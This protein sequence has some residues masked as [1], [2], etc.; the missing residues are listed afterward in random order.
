[1]SKNGHF[2]NKNTGS[3]LAL[4]LSPNLLHLQCS[5]WVF[6]LNEH[7]QHLIHVANLL[8]SAPTTPH[9]IL[10]ERPK[11]QIVI[12]DGIFCYKQPTILDVFYIY[13]YVIDHGMGCWTF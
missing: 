5:L 9:N 1:M 4:L 6:L 11:R 7:T 8:L 13:I 3:N 12:F 2:A 10:D